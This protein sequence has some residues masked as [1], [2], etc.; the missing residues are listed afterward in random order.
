[1]NV[2][3]NRRGPG[4]VA[5]WAEPM[6]QTSDKSRSSR[7]W[8][9]RRAF[10]APLLVCAVT[11]CA[12]SGPNRGQA[13]QG[14][15]QTP[16]PPVADVHVASVPRQNL[17][18]GEL[19]LVSGADSVLVTSADLGDR[20]VRVET[21]AT[22]SL[23]PRVSSQGGQ[24]LVSLAEVAGGGGGG[25]QVNIVLDKKV[26]WRVSLSGGASQEHVDLTGAR[27]KG[28]T[29]AAGSSSITAVLPPPSGDVTVL[30][31]GGASVFLVQTPSGVPVQVSFGGGA[32]TATIDGDIHSGIAGGTVIPAPGW[33]AAANRYS[34]V[35]SAGVS[36]FTLIRHD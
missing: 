24:F 10:V 21:P 30:M 12:C 14:W 25:R 22:A 17:T 8:P 34:I 2:I 33:P 20:L 13:S 28:L 6:I 11:A 3:H 5:D 18:V 36:A 26:A 31:A 19:D 7:G 16:V 9:R 35:N 23:E 29:F 15:P 27:L 1:M 32:G 4:S